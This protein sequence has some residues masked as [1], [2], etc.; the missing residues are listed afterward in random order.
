MV[1]FES[2]LEETSID[3]FLDAKGLSEKPSHEFEFVPAPADLKAYVNSLYI[4]NVGPDGLEEVLPSYSGQ[5]LFTCEGGGRMD[6]GTGY[7]E[8]PAR[9]CFIGPLSKAHPFVLEGPTQV[10]GVSLTFKGW[11]ALTGLAVVQNSDRFV[12]VESGLGKPIAKQ[13]LKLLTDL[14]SNSISI[15]QA[16]DRLAEL[17]RKRIKP[18]PES[19]AHLI[20]VTYEWLSSSFNP[21]NDQLYERLAL[22]KRQ[23]QRLVKRFFGLP[24]SRLK[25]RYRAIRAATL[26]SDPNL[27][28]AVL[29]ELLSSF[30]DQPHMIREIR[31][32]TGRTPRI[33]A[34]GEGS[35]VTDMLGRN[36]Y[37]IV[38][39]FGGGEEAQLA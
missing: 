19:H 7:V 1:V 8:A 33:L 9:V 26:L 4:L 22:S 37:G 13:A 17:L 20:D 34:G 28:E 32:F 10:L 38:D 3:Q 35:I 16:I 29:W 39:L 11:A 36:G 25:R 27:D 6:F 31:E 30:Y 14:C 5:L 23:A 12:S 24:P 21:K 2:V 15:S 18:L